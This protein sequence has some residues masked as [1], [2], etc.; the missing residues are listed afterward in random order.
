LRRASGRDA[1]DL[2]RDGRRRR[3]QLLEQ[4]VAGFDAVLAE[5][6]V[7]PPAYA[8]AGT[9]NLGSVETSTADA[10]LFG[11]LSLDRPFGRDLVV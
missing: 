9:V 10:D 3:P 6:D 4:L 7:N 2:E 5:I 1:L 11:R 8:R